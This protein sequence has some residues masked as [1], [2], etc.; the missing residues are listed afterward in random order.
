MKSKI[1][2]SLLVLNLPVAR[3]MA[4]FGVASRY[5]AEGL[6]EAT[7]PLFSVVCSGG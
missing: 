6:A 7:R 5:V 4:P 3:V 2:L 1:Y